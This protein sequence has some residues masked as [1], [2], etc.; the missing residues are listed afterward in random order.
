MATPFRLAGLLRL[1]AMQEEQA[2]AE[3]ARANASLRA[4]ERR[5]RRTAQALAES[6]LPERADDLSWQAAVAGR[7]AASG[8]LTEAVAARDT[9]DFRVRRATGDWSDAR[10]SALMIRKLE[11]RH[12]AALEAEEL[13]LEQLVLDEA[14][15]RRAVPTMPT[16]R[17]TPSAAPVE[18]T[19]PT[20][21]AGPA[22]TGT[23]LQEKDR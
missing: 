20:A 1:R 18:R 3:L 19:A 16:A 21:P 13:R 17:P 4:A 9:V 5:E 14:A 22:G 8:L 12:Q 10:A 2:A 15:S 6:E 23:D 7:A 11:E